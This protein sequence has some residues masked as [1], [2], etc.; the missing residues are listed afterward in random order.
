VNPLVLLLLAAA[1]APAG[2]RPAA[3]D[4]KPKIS[5]ASLRVL[6]KSFDGRVEKVGSADSFYLLGTTRGIYL[7]GFGAVFT[8]ELNLIVSPNLSPFRPAFTKEEI[9]Q[10]RARKLRQV[11]ALKATMREMLAAAAAALGEM[12]AGERIVL[13]VSLFYYS[14]EDRSGLPSQIVMQGERGKLLDRAGLKAAVRTEEL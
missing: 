4:E 2:E 10:V 3:G 9:A 6:E 13:G 7:E 14:W 1:A 8:A 5:R 11:T 12:P